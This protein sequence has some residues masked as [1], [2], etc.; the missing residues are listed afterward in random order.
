MESSIARR[1][2]M[3][4]GTAATLLPRRGRAAA[5]RTIKIGVMNDM[6]GPLSGDG[7]KGS[8]ACVQQ[9]IRDLGAIGFDVDVLSGDHQNKPDVGAAIAREWYDQHG[10]DMI[11]DVP[12]SSIAFNVATL[13]KE[14]NKV[15]I[16]SGS[17][18][19]DLT[20]KACNANMIQWTYDTYMLSRS[21]GTQVVKAGG[22]KWYFVTA[23][24]V[25][26]HQLQDD[27]AKFVQQ[28]G[29]KVLGAVAFPYPGQTDFS[30]FLVQAQ[31]SG[32]NVLALNANGADLVNGIKQAHEFGLARSMRLAVPIATINN[33]RELGDQAEGIY[34]TETFYWDLND[35]TRAFTKRVRPT[36]PEQNP[37]NM[38]QAG[39]YSGA[40]HYLKAVAALGAKQA[41]DG[42]AVVAK[43]KQMPSDDDAFGPGSVRIDGR[44]LFPAYLFEVVKSD[45]DPWA[46]YKLVATTPP[47]EAW[48]PVGR[49]CPLVHA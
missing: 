18:S 47:T 12:I 22:D 31:A 35:R 5:A 43:M 36:M 15:F 4:G 11:I 10:V 33:I 3:A 34:L 44:G 42:A 26:G 21:V 20:G 40:T 46:C 9:A 23:D 7:G 2:V 25:F 13:A 24:Y 17:G 32:A 19:T 38:M 30:S 39:C 16:T 48:P 27:T 28:A 29:G 14:K 1:S 6:T 45:K 49:G 41:E 8:T 37:P